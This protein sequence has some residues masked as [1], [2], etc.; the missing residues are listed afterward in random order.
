[1]F[2]SNQVEQQVVIVRGNHHFIDIKCIRNC[3]LNRFS[4]G[5]VIHLEALCLSEKRCS[6][7]ATFHWT[8]DDVSLGKAQRCLYNPKNTQDSFQFKVEV[9]DQGLVGIASMKLTLNMPP[10][11]GSCSI[12]PSKGVAFETDFHIQC[13]NYDDSDAPLSY[14][15]K[16]H[17][18]PLERSND[19]QALLKL[20]Q[21]HEVAIVICDQWDAC[22]ETQVLVN[23]SSLP[24]P[25]NIRD[26]LAQGG[27]NVRSLISR[28]HRLACMILAKS[29]LKYMSRE[30]DALELLNE[31]ES[32]K[33]STLL[34]VEQWLNICHDLIINLIP[35]DNRKSL[36]LFGYLSILTQ[37]LQTIV[38]DGEIHDIQLESYENAMRQLWIMIQEFSMPRETMVE[39]Q[40]IPHE[41]ILE[42]DPLSESYN[43]MSDFDL[44][45]LDRIANWLE[46]SRELHKCFELLSIQAY[47]MYQPLETPFTMEHGSLRMR[48]YAFEDTTDHYINDTIN[49]SQLYIP[50]KDIEDLQRIYG[51]KQIIFQIGSMTANSFWWY[52]H[53]LG[54]STNL[55]YFATRTQKSSLSSLIHLK[56][57]Y[58]FKLQIQNLS[59]T[60]TFEGVIKDQLHMPI[61]ALEIPSNAALVL[62]LQNCEEDVLL[63]INIGSKPKSFQIL[64]S[65]RIFKSMGGI[66]QSYFTTNRAWGNRK[67]YIAIMATRDV[68]KF[69]F[70][71]KVFLSIIQCLHW[72]WDSTNP[73]W[74]SE[75]CI[76]KLGLNVSHELECECFHLSTFAAR[77][78]SSPVKEDL[79]QRFLLESLPFN[80]NILLFYAVIILMCTA[81][82]LYN[83]YRLQNHRYLLMSDASIGDNSISVHIYTGS[84]ENAAST[85]NIQLRFISGNGPYSVSIYQTPKAPQ[86]LRNSLTELRLGSQ[87]VQIPLKI[88]ISNSLG[89]RYPTWYCWKIS[90]FNR[91]TKQFQLFSIKK[92]IS[93]QT[94]DVMPSD[95]IRSFKQKFLDNFDNFYI[96]WFQFQPIFG[97][98]IFTDAHAYQRSCIWI[99]QLMVSLCIVACY[100]RPTTMESYEE[101]RDIYYS[102]HFSN[103]ELLALPLACFLSSAIVKSLF[104]IHSIVS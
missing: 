23:V 1:M 29:I 65:G 75:G 47:Q 61:Y 38:A 70:S 90:I 39:V 94:L 20:P 9:W 3:L 98:V 36:A 6:P 14:Q 68:K 40:N 76:A 32:L 50:R 4:H 2:I 5:H 102:L 99:S 95:S 77:S 37:G 84:L 58:V 45:V 69:P 64:K 80:W 21:C 87:D 52:P 34:E 19:P 101:E 92:W 96:N 66:S 83:Y 30:T 33:L 59:S 73:Q 57:P 56:E 35:L 60:I 72:D 63:D 13:E 7:N 62:S 26:F 8:L 81:I 89:G 28:G 46:T 78:Y 11:T 51:S 44:S 88:T 18:F 86:L 27:T 100:Y 24:E 31:V 22:I 79:R 41:M 49:S 12:K 15:Y 43:E 25:E 16:I 42:T 55:L 97:P 54:V 17:D 85:A 71:F 103:I 10:A 104:L 67:A 48:I 82:I 91:T 53:N 74:S 93:K